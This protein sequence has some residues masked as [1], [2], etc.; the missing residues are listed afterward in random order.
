[1]TRGVGPPSIYC[2]EKE[3]SIA[4]LMRLRKTQ[5]PVQLGSVV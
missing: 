3:I 1:M 5:L 2:A 4:M